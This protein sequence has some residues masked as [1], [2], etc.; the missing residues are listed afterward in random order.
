M[1]Y[2]YT[3]HS[4]PLGGS[5]WKGKNNKRKGGGTKEKLVL[6]LSLDFPKQFVSAHVLSFPILL[7]PASLHF[8]LAYQETERRVGK[9]EGHK[10]LML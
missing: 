4:G 3:R 6:R 8:M 10:N 9:R 5:G 7:V 2:E 1:Q